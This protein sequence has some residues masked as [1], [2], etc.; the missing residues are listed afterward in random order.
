MSLPYAELLRAAFRVGIAPEVFWNLTPREL[1]L[2]THALA[3]GSR[4]RQRICAGAADTQCE[5]AQSVRD[6]GARGPPAGM[7]ADRQSL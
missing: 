6:Q 4:E 2:L 1:L 7:A 5:R 3:A